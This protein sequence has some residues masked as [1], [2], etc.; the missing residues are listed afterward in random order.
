MIQEM[1]RNL[2]FIFL[3]NSEK[4]QQLFTEQGL[5]AIFCHQNA[6]LDENRYKITHVMKKYDAIYIARITPFKRHELAAGITSLSLVGDYSEREKKY[7]DKIFDLLSHAEW[8]RKILSKN[9]YKVINEARVGLCLSAEEGAMFVSAEYL[10]CGLPIVNTP[11]LGGRDALFCTDY[12][13]TIQ[14]PTAQK[15]ASAVAALIEHKTSPNEIRDATIALMAVH[16]QKFIDLIQSI[17]DQ[18]NC[19]KIFSA[20]WNKVFIHKMGLRSTVPIP[21]FIKRILKGRDCLG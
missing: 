8:K 21:L 2:N 5:N 13:I 19:K 20:E 1:K 15:I 16:R 11:N 17:Y 12:V 14:N 7:C 6:F 9:I 4:E 10:L 3:C 18:E